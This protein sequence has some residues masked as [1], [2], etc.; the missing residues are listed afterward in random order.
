MTVD[1]KG[2]RMNNPEGMPN[3]D[4]VMRG[5]DEDDD[6]IDENENQ[7]HE[8]TNESNRKWF[9][10]PLIIAA[11]G[12]LILNLIITSVISNSQDSTAREQ[13][14]IIEKRLERIETDLSSTVQAI[15]ELKSNIRRTVKQKS[16]TKKH[17]QP[18]ETKRA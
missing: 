11:V 8:R 13:L 5:S 2:S 17:H 18:N 12:F 16:P 1:E 10:M 15:E 3:Q 6:A 4:F 9:S 14:L 7:G